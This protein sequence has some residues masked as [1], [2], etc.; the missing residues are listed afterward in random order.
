[1]ISFIRT[2]IQ[3]LFARAH[4]LTCPRSLWQHLLDGLRARGEGVHEAGAFLLGTESNG[5]RR[6]RSVVFYDE[7]DPRAYDSGVC[8][9]HGDAFAK[10]WGLCREKGLSVVGDIHTHPGSAHQ[11]GADR[12][13]PMIARPGHIALIVARFAKAPV[14]MAALGLY[15]YLG[16]HRWNDFSGAKAERHFRIDPWS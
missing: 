16:G 9:L 5:K 6:V 1:M 8:V 3:A 15:Q 11:S 10:L 7:L 13:N 2:T 12:T 14:H 4:E